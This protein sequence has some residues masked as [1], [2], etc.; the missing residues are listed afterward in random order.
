MSSSYNDNFTSSL[1]IW[2]R[3]LFLVWLLWLG[4][5]ILCWREVVRVG[6]SV[7][8]QILVGRLSVF[9]HWVYYL[10]WVVII[11]FYYVEVCSLYTHFCKGFYHEWML[12][13]IKCFF[14]IC[15]DDDVVFVLSLM[16]C[17]TLIDLHM[18]NHLC[19]SGMNPTWLWC[20]TIFMCCWIRF[21]NILLRIF[22][23]IFIKDICL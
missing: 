5:P 10:L 2:I 1:P 15:G 11:S 18:L 19:D 14:C 21:A 22:A 6:I 7:L 4:F 17:I 12:N 9:H 13:F 8:F 20:M 16:W 3:F 23:S